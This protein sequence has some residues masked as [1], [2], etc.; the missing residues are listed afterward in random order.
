MLRL[1]RRFSFSA[2]PKRFLMIDALPF[3]VLSSPYAVKPYNERSP[4]KDQGSD[5]SLCS[6]PV[7]R[8]FTYE[9]GYIFMLMNSTDL[10][11]SLPQRSCSVC[12]AVLEEMADCYESTC[13]SCKGVTF[14]PIYPAAEKTIGDEQRRHV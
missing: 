6:I 12:G 5:S 13:I 11:N 9:R 14:Y 10:M 8:Q 4:S 2:G 3:F 7:Q 1:L